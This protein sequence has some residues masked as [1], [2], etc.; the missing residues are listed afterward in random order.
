MNAFLDAFG[1]ETYYWAMLD[2]RRHFTTGYE[3][4][5][6]FMSRCILC[7]VMLLTGCLRL[8]SQAIVGWAVRD[9]ASL[10]FAPGL[11]PF[12]ENWDPSLQ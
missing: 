2:V 3:S 6:L 9:V 4:C 7:Y 5:N 10:L 1:V 8:Q 11:H 12:W